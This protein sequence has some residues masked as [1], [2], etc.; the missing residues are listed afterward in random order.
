MKLRSLRRVPLLVWSLAPSFSSQA[1][2]EGASANSPPAE[3]LRTVLELPLPG[4]QAP[5]TLSLPQR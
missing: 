5:S 3:I 4:S 2:S 1:A